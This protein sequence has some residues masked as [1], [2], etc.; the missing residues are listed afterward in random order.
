MFESAASN[1]K[2]RVEREAWNNSK[3]G[4]QQCIRSESALLRFPRRPLGEIR[5]AKMSSK[6]HPHIRVTGL[7]HFEKRAKNGRR[8]GATPFKAPRRSV[9]DERK[10]LHECAAENISQLS[11]FRFT[12]EL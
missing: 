10:T 4:I 3:N 9:I 6:W 1:S 7:Q 12:D 2:I 5:I 11:T 8:R